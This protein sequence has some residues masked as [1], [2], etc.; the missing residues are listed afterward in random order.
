MRRGGERGSRKE[1]E[2]MRFHVSKDLLYFSHR[3]SGYIIIYKFYACIFP[4]IQE[5]IFL[6]CNQLTNLSWLQLLPK[7]TGLPFLTCRRLIPNSCALGRCIHRVTVTPHVQS[8]TLYIYIHIVY[9]YAHT[10]R[11]YTHTHTELG[12]VPVNDV[13]S[14]GRTFFSSPW[15][16][17]ASTSTSTPISF[18]CLLTDASSLKLTVG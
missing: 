15:S 4:K 9:I 13:T 11:E 7:A 12:L 3:F 2:G 10:E 17:A 8:T 6:V 5:L 18:K 1:V 14:H 16:A